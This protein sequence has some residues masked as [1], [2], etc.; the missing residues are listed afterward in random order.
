M[1]K[2]FKNANFCQQLSK[3]AKYLPVA[4]EFQQLYNYCQLNKILNKNIQIENKRYDI[5]MSFWE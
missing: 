5:V 4:H 1:Q 3:D 2:N